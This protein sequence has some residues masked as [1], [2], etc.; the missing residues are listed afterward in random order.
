MSEKTFLD[1]AIGLD[2]EGFFDA[3][4]R[5]V[6]Q[7]MRAEFVAGF[8]AVSAKLRDIV[9]K[10]AVVRASDVMVVPARKRK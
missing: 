4:R 1:G 7:A 3:E 9:T 6:E 5:R 2:E 10:E 8:E